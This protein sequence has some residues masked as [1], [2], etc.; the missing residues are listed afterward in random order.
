M[1]IFLHITALLNVAEGLQTRGQGIALVQNIEGKPVNEVYTFND[2]MRAFGREYTAGSAEY[3]QRAATFDQSLMQINMWNSRANRSWTAGVHPFMDWTAAERE[4]R[5]HGYEPTTPRRLTPLL[6]RSS[7]ALSH[8]QRLGGEHD[9]FEAETPPVRNQ[10]GFCGSCWATAAI[11]AVEAQLI[12]SKSPL[13]RQRLS[14]QALVDCVSNPKH[15]GGRGGCRGATPELAFDFMQSTGVPLENNLPYE[16]ED[17][18]CPINPF[19]EDWARVT[20]A[21]WRQ[22]P[23]NQAQPLMRAL[24][25]DGPVVVAVD[26]H[27]WYHFRSGIFDGCQKDAVPNHSVLAKGY[28]VASGADNPKGE[29]HSPL[30]YWL[31]QNSWGTEWGESGFIRLFRH[32]DEDGW[33]GTDRRPQ[34]GNACDDE[35]NR[36]VTVCGSCGILYDGAVPEVG[37]VTIPRDP[38][39][40]HDAMERE[41]IF[42]KTVGIPGLNEHLEGSAIPDFTSHV[43]FEPP[44]ATTTGGPT[45]SHVSTSDSASQEAAVSD[46]QGSTPAPAH[47]DEHSDLEA[48]RL[49]AV[50][51]IDTL[52]RSDG[53]KPISNGKAGGPVDAF[54]EDEQLLSAQL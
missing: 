49:S 51:A 13:G 41:A 36:A 22:L 21:G 39:A 53:D 37:D 29:T 31:I 23:S 12:K 47:D 9:S 25:E 50:N 30:K 19:P 15:C 24:V 43:S 5:L 34:E 18:K 32:D 44:A 46:Q 26:A 33:C 3:T 52:T 6:Q 8:K 14:V 42:E 38:G 20:L 4:Q 17:G 16:Q 2:F 7:E 45:E 48:R 1:S 54:A 28:G 10:G 40:A 27:G 11:E 35:R